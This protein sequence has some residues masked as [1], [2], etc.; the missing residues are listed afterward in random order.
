MLGH[1]NR[2]RSRFYASLATGLDA[3]L[4]LDAALGLITEDPFATPSKRLLRAVHQG[5]S[6]AE[7]MGREKAAFNGFEARAIAAGEVS[8][9]LV[10]V[11]QRLADRYE[12][13]GKILDRIGSALVYPVV[14]IH[15][16]VLLPPLFILF[17]DGLGAYL[18]TVLPIF[19]VLYALAAVGRIAARKV[20]A[21]EGQ[22]LGTARLLLGIPIVG[23][24]ARALALS[25]YAFV[26]GT[27]VAAGV[28]L[29]EALRQAAEANGNAVLT[30]AGHRVTQRVE[31]G[32]EL[33]PALTQESVFTRLFVETVK[34]GETAGS[35][36]DALS[37]AESTCREDASTAISRL[38]TVLPIFVMVAVGVIV[39]WVVI[40]SFTSVLGGAS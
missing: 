11:L 36:D 33:W 31:E 4:T 16:A 1:K 14:L 7:A 12:M 5:K 37:R 15:A 30:D 38:A 20:A 35:L 40:A 19:V 10:E 39:A 3:G 22:R 13:R 24:I 21:N 26:L 29:L 18:A 25:D 23:G 34:V 9:H 2:Q 32:G 6:L 27:L 8:G 17:R 28:P